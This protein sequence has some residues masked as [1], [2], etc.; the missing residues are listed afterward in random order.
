MK[1]VLREGSDRDAAAISELLIASRRAFI[2]YAPMV[3]SAA[4][5]HTWVQGTLIPS[6]GVTVACNPETIVGL[7]ATSLAE[8]I[9]WIDQLYILP[10]SVGKGIG[11]SLLR[12]GLASLAR[13]VRLY[14][15]QA[16]AG[17]RRFYE[18]HGFRATAFSD[19]STNEENCP[20][21]LFEL[22]A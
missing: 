8:G 6:R 1:L 2:P 19:G 17:A 11:S 16:N 20:D 13:P 15:F 9:A 3:H 7:L 22:A 18:K 21:V 14:T 4:E 5:V 12:H 10:E